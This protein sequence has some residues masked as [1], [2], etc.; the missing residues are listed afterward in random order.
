MDGDSNNT[1]A[2][3]WLGNNVE[4]SF[5]LKIA[6]VSRSNAFSRKI[7]ELIKRIESDPSEFGR[8]VKKHNLGEKTI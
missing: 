4:R 1:L 2:N 5:S 3:A 8:L 6:S 7:S